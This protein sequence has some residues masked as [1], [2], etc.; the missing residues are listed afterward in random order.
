MMDGYFTGQSQKQNATGSLT[1][2]LSEGYKWIRKRKRL[3]S[4]GG[5]EKIKRRGRPE[6]F[7]VMKRGMVECQ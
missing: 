3:D 4:R 6:G 5:R 1:G 2:F 7:I